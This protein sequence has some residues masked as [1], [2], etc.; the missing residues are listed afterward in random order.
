MREREREKVLIC[1]GGLTTEHDISIITA[2]TIYEK[3]RLE[4]CDVKLLYK[5]RDGKWFIG[6]GLEKFSAYKNFNP[7][8]YEE[9]CFMYGEQGLY[10][11]KK[12]KLTKL[13]DVGF[14][15]NCF[16]GGAG[17][18]GRFAGFLE[19]C[20]IP[21]SSSNYKALGVS[22]DKYLTKLSAIAL[23]VQV[24]DFFVFSHSEWLN[25]QDRV[26]QQLIQFD[27]P[28]VVKPSCQ[29]SSIGVS[30][31]KSI[32]EFKQ[33]VSVGF[34]FDSSLIV[35][36]AVINKREFN[37]CVIKTI[38][39]KLVARLDEPITKKVIISFSDKYLNGTKGKGKLKTS[40]GS[41]GMQ[42]QLK[43]KN[44]NLSTKLRA[45]ILKASKTIYQNLDM[46][47]VVRF[48]YLFDTKKEKVYLGEINAIPGSL[49]YYFYED[50]NL[51]KL[52]YNSGKVYWSERFQAKTIGAP[53]VF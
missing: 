49:G 28:V 13:F 3:Y 4:N 33:A 53:T 17:E 21:S 39:G 24:L 1:Y 52:L 30:L 7:K 34:K 26:I 38:E 31:V 35:E 20:K 22:M 46:N 14:V 27:F 41:L 47:G 8:K 40:S 2:I 36:R 10:K 32:E 43:L 29:G 37:C 15:V 44:V 51:L 45:E 11:C 18:D 9:V 25:G 19:E 12:N 48:D 16:H 5:S 23:D 6:D 42:N 50:E